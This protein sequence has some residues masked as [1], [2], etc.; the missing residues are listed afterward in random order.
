MIIPRVG[1]GKKSHLPVFKILDFSFGP[2]TMLKVIWSTSGFSLK[3]IGDSAMVSTGRSKLKLNRRKAALMVSEW[4]LWNDYYLP[5]SGVAGKTVLDV[6]AGCGESTALMF[7]KGAKMVVC[8]EPS[9][10]EV[11]YLRENIKTNGW[12]CE[13]IPSGFD[14]SMLK[15]E[16]DFV[17]MDCE[18]CEAALIGLEKLPS[19]IAE[20]HSVELKDKFIEKGMR[21][22]K[23]MSEHT[24]IMSNAK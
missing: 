23:E 2:M 17:K 18:G 21:V 24:F 4:K 3:D 9:Q 12:N 10:E 5:S 20:V 13:V 7:E 6:G 14:L 1:L 19:V 11:A 15:S 16:I 22:T 8:V